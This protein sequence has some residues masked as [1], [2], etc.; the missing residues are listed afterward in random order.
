MSGGAW[1]QGPPSWV[2][3]SPKMPTSQTEDIKTIQSNAESTGDDSRNPSANQVN[4][5]SAGFGGDRREA[6]IRPS[7]SQKRATVRRDTSP[8]YPGK[9]NRNRKREQLESQKHTN[10]TSASCGTSLNESGNNSDITVVNVHKKD[11]NKLGYKDLVEW[12]KQPNHLYIG[13]DMTRF[14]PGAVHSKWHNPN[15]SKTV[16]REQ[17]CK[18]FREYILADKTIQSNGKTLLQSLGELKGKTLGCWCH[19]EMCH[20]HVLREL[21]KEFCS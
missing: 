7:S 2:Q 17:S 18:M 9:V 21:V 14:V 5:T 4:R 16:G 13:R 6:L 19:P 10:M 1:S 20:G 11:L 15:K 3:T 8:W 12:I